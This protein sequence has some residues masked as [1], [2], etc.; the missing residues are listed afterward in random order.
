MTR[1]DQSWLLPLMERIFPALDHGGVRWALLRGRADLSDAARDV[2]LLVARADLPALEKVVEELGGVP[3]PRWLQGWHRFYWFRRSGLAKP[4]LMLDVVTTLT[5]GRDGRLPTDLA[6]GCLERRVRVGSTYDLSPTDAFWTI[7]L[8]CLL[9]KGG[10]KERRAQELSAAL[11]GLVRPSDGEAVVADIC[12]PGWSPDRLIECVQRGDWEAVGRLG[13]SLIGAAAAQAGS[14]DDR[15]LGDRRTRH[16]PAGVGA[17]V[18]RRLPSRDSRAGHAA[19][20]LYA[21][22]W[23]LTHQTKGRKRTRG[24][25]MVK[26]TQLT[27][28]DRPVRVSL[29]GLD[30]SGKSRQTAALVADL[31]TERSVELVWVPFDIWPGTMLKF[32]P[33]RVRV[34]LGPRGRTVATEHLTVEQ[35][36]TRAQDAQEGQLSPHRSTQ[37]LVRS[38]WW[39]VATFAAISAGV[40]LGR[41]L[42]R[43]T[44][45]LVVLDRYRLDTIVKLQSWYPTVSPT[46]VARIVLRLTPT[47]DVECLLRVS[48]TEAYARKPEQYNVTQLTRQAALYDQLVAFVPGAFA[49]NGQDNPE[50][51]TAALCASVRKALDGR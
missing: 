41:R 49:V 46:W 29:S 47:P 18:K 27:K 10:V 35:L 6:D 2:D 24:T 48:G 37:P 44:A 8:H 26:G 17:S 21:A 5:Y 20:T 15:V 7:L 1:T 30:G 36:A 9:D 32:L 19:K 34:L 12:P 31:S 45:E 33:T 25:Q 28:Q 11:P 3:L 23:K 13:R 43:V 51:V 14:S 42:N 4:G 40:S 39:C 38:F 16:R 22:G 50:A